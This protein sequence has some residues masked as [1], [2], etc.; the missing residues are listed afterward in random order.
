MAFEY[1]SGTLS[2]ISDERAL[3]LSSLLTDRHEPLY[4]YN[5]AD[6]KKRLQWYF[7][8]FRRPVKVRYALKANSFP[9]LLREMALA[10]AG[11]DVVSGG[12][13]ERA[14]DA[15]IDPKLI[16]FSG[17]GKSEEEIRL[18]IKSGIGQI[19]VESLPELKRIGQVA[20]SQ[21]KKARIALR[22]N[23]DVTAQ[24]HQYVATGGKEN[25]FGLDILQIPDAVEILRT[26]PEYLQFFGVAVHIGSQLMDVEPI[27]RAV[28]RMREVFMSL[29]ANGWPVQSLDIGGGLGIDYG[30]SN[31]V[32]DQSRLIAYARRIEETLDNLD[33]DIICEPGRFLVARAGALLTRVEY[34]KRTPHQTFII[35]NSGINHLLRP[36]LYQA[37]HRIVPV[38]DDVQ[39]SK[40]RCDIVGPICESSDVLGA[41]RE[42][43][44]PMEGE[45]L[46]VLDTGAY[47]YSMASRYNLRPL[48]GE[49]LVHA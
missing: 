22:L 25:K 34:V 40:V 19:N 26:F 21:K 36:A 16:V 38:V 41:G 42:I 3:P 45:W 44:L 9:G 49:T 6:V 7:G 48:P 33:A 8:A 11:A 24:T 46:A 14:L 37:V 47:G 43:G 20:Q 27:A 2:A 1:V 32:T 13:L 31:T 5:W 17:V 18:A 29:R 23:P 30:G 10:G 15:G 39:R 28:G 35:V 4:V 12:E